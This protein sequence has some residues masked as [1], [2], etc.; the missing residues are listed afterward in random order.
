MYWSLTTDTC[1]LLFPWNFQRPRYQTHQV[2]IPL[3]YVQVA[4][5]MEMCDLQ[6]GIGALPANHGAQSETRRI[7]QQEMSFNKRLFPA[8]PVLVAFS[9]SFSL[10]FL[11]LSRYSTIISCHRWDK[12]GKY[13]STSDG[14]AEPALKADRSPIILPC[15]G[16]SREE[17]RRTSSNLTMK[18]LFTVVVAGSQYLL[19]PQK[20]V[21]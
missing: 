1:I 20:L 19:H 5:E 18:N 10:S 2:V 7:E 13:L 3:I 15:L 9:F 8:S 21:R 12:I 16:S 17:Q 4:S 14:A 6:T 11:L